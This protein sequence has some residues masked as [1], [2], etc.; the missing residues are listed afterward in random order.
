MSSG[1]ETWPQTLDLAGLAIK[2]DVSPI[3]LQALV[4]MFPEG[5]Q[6]VGITL[7]LAELDELVGVLHAARAELRAIRKD[8]EDK[9]QAARDF[10]MRCGGFDAARAAFVAAAAAESVGGGR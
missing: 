5:G 1:I 4:Q 2:V 8:R 10:V 9:N 7:E 3:N 6:G